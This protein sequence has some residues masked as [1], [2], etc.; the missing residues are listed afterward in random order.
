VALILPL[1]NG[2]N[3]LFKLEAMGSM[4]GSGGHGGGVVEEAGGQR[5][6]IRHC[7]GAR[8]WGMGPIEHFRIFAILFMNI[9]GNAQPYSP[10]FPNVIDSPIDSVGCH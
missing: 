8:D 1:Q 3:L 2:A 10:A 9:L 4:N 6:Q 7:H 5:S